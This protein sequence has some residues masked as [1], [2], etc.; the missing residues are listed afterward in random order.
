MS[1]PKTL[2]CFLC[3]ATSSVFNDLDTLATKFPTKEENLVYGSV[4]DLYAWMRAFDAINSLSDKLI[5]KKWRPGKDQ[6]DTVE[7]RKNIRNAA[8]KD[9]MNLLVDAARSGGVGNSN[10]GNTARRAFQDEA[11][12]AQITG[13]DQGLI[14]DIH[15]LLI[16]INVDIPLNL[17]KFRAKGYATA[18]KWV[19]LYPWYH[20]PVTL[21]QL[22]LHAWESIPQSSLPLS[23]FSEQSLESCNKNFKNDREHHSRKDTRLHTI[24][25]QFH[26]QSDKADLKMALKLHEKR[27]KKKSLDLP[28]D[29]LDFLEIA[30]DESTEEDD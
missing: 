17:E 6:K 20:M 28:P 18:K 10:T 25:D 27:P 24:Q 19:E 4:C 7:S 1:R 21:H 3:N 8:Y 23:F 9:Q 5:A 12:F 14:H 30:E 22:F 11:T 2:R 26:R 29:V 13:V 15:T 16:G